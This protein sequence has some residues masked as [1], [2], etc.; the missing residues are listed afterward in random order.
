MIVAGIDP[1][2][3]GGIAVLGES[4]SVELIDDIP[5]HQIPS[6]AKRTLRAELDVGG[7]I[8]LLGRYRV[9]DI[10]VERVAARPGQGVTSMFR[11]GYACGVIHGVAM[12]MTIPI[13]FVT[14]QSWQ[15][16]HGC[17]PAPDAARQRATQLYPAAASL[18]T[19]KKDSH[20]ADALLIASY[21]HAKLEAM[22]ASWA[23]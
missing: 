22:K 10:F 4:G 16:F 14:P 5:V 23:T 15:K 2:L 1:G 21:G 17:G 19:R 8:I 6:G 20:R 7:L 12:A 9:G 13:T 11:F 18:L 3:H